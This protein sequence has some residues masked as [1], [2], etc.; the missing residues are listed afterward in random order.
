VGRGVTRGAAQR[1]ET[2]DG[3]VLRSER[4]RELIAGALY[5]L[6]GEGHP[7]PTA[8][9]VAERAGVGIR[10]VFRL[11]SDM[12]ALYATMNARLLAEVRPMLRGGPPEGADLGERA[13]SLVADR[14]ALFERVA[15]YL[16]ATNLQCGR[17]SFLTQEHRKIVGQLRARL[18][19][20]LPKLDEA[21]ADLV[22]ALDQAT[23]FEAWD[24]LRSD[25]RLG[26]PRARAAMQRAVTALVRELEDGS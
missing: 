16:R 23:S 2:T 14:A 26:R 22:E 25:Q 6:V 12:E 1:G 4:S 19:R 20:W 17:S 13:T 10:T 3:R 24:R 21:P 18:L 9:Q 5:E 11:F 15:P 7:E 8:Q